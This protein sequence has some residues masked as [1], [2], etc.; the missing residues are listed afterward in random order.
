MPLPEV[1]AGHV[2][3]H[4]HAHDAPVTR[5]P[6]VNVSVEQ[7]DYRPLSLA[8][9][10]RLAR[11][12][13]EGHYPAGRAPRS[14]AC[15]RW[16]R[17]GRASLL[18]PAGRVAA[19]AETPTTPPTPR[20]R[21]K[22]ERPRLPGHGGHDPAGA[23]G[24]VCRRAFPDMADGAVRRERTSR[25]VDVVGR[26]PER[27]EAR[28]MARMND[29]E[30]RMRA[31][32]A[33]HDRLAPPDRLLVARLDG[34]GFHALTRALELDKPYDQGFRDAMVEAGRQLM[35]CG[36]EILYVYTQS[37]ELS[38]LFD[39]RDEAFNH[40][41]RKLL[42]VLAAEASASLTLAFGR[43]A[44]MDCRLLE[45]ENVGEVG[46]YFRWRQ[47]DAARNCQQSHLYWALRRAGRSGRAAYREALGLSR[48]AIS[49]RLR[50]LAG[51]DYDALPAWQRHGAG[52]YRESY[53][54][55]GVN[56]VT[57]ERRMAVR[58]RIRV[59]FELPYGGG[60][61]AL[62]AGLLAGARKP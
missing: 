32:E 55:E 4:G 23:R 35:Q 34:R 22:H 20:R 14:G 30:V 46:D 43:I 19:S 37:D 18:R 2:N 29:I 39:P 7:L 60:H 31:A 13:V 33:R 51:I 28:R 21:T 47:A 42:S 24:G 27:P 45:L 15:A 54:K 38:V 36:M 61:A 3:V 56:P 9:L 17:R 1:P 50:E 48:D 16:R 53:E 11:R 10:R 58:R 57:G 62:V 12:L 5:T 8:R 59:E 41:H 52:L 25:A 26:V 40:R 44:S 49:A 6:H